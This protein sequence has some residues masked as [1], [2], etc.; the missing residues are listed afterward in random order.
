MT[1]HGPVSLPMMLILAP[2]HG[3]G[4]LPSPA[5]QQLVVVEA[6]AQERLFASV[7]QDLFV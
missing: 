4:C 6:S 5:R 2:R 7:G 1:A 3:R